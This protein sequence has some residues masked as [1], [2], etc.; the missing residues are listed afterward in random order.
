MIALA[1][2]AR[3]SELMKYSILLVGVCGLFAASTSSTPEP[4][5]AEPQV[6]RYQLVPSR[7]HITVAGKYEEVNKVY[8]IDTAT[9]QVWE[10]VPVAFTPPK[11]MLD[12]MTITACGWNAIPDSYL[13]EYLKLGPLY[14][15][16]QA[17][18]D[19]KGPR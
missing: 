9:G 16:N 3:S 2:I 8:K 1:S 13:E 4:T 18:V 10:Y 17:P 7:V 5:T 12:G 6:G 14:S 19:L 15:T 11:R